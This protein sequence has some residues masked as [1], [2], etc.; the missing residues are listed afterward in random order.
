MA[1]RERAEWL[2]RMGLLVF[3]LAAAAFL[4][5]VTTIRIAIR[6][7]QVTMP[8]LVGKNLTEAQT[9][10]DKLKIGLRVADRVYDN[11]SAG[12]IVRQSPPPGIEVKEGQTAHVV[13]SL[14]PMRVTVPALEGA[15]LRSARIALLQAGLQLGEVSAPYVDNSIAETVV[16]QAPRAG[17]Q[18]TTPRVDVLAPAGPRPTALVMPFL[19]GLN[20]ADAQRTLTAAGVEGVRITPVPAMQWPTG[21][22]IDQ[23]PLGGARLLKTGPAEIKVAMPQ[24]PPGNGQGGNS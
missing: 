17:T 7:R 18:A 2:M 24:P 23:A 1:L 5:A 22:V 12:S 13:V 19:I 8:N 20:E 9:T 11:H 10:L 14:G 4:S 21:T 16:V 6:S 3:I 15:S